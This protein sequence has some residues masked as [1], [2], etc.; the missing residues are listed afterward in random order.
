MD[1][2]KTTCPCCRLFKPRCPEP[3]V[4][5]WLFPDAPGPTSPQIPEKDKD[6]DG[7]GKQPRTP[8]TPDEND[9]GAKAS[10]PPT[11]YHTK[12]GRVIHNPIRRTSVSGSSTRAEKASPGTSHLFTIN[13]SPPPAGFLPRCASCTRKRPTT[14]TS[15][16]PLYI[17]IISPISF[18]PV[19]SPL[20]LI[21]A[22]Y[23]AASTAAAP[24]EGGTASMPG[25]SSGWCMPSATASAATTRALARGAPTHQGRERRSHAS[26]SVTCQGNRK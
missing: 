2:G 25:G 4:S 14:P 12:T 10:S 16:Q 23:S 9:N 19:P 8:S 24:R 21:S 17:P 18:P 1:P 26:S 7:S 6:S 22:P 3:P 20:P 5:P 11:P 13:S 15:E